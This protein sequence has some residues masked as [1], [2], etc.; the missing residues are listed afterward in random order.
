LFLFI[1]SFQKTFACDCEMATVSAESISKYELIFVGKVVAISGCDES[2]KAN[3]AVEKL[4]RGK[5]F[6]ATDVEFDCSSDCQMSFVPGQTWII[7]ATYEKY[8]EPKVH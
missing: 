1:F 6:S 3:F 4:F 5:C 8:G 2:A 7:Y